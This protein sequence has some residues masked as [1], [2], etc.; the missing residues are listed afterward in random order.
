MSHGKQRV[1]GPLSPTPALLWWSGELAAKGRPHTRQGPFSEA[2][3]LN[4]C[5]LEFLLQIHGTLDVPAEAL[6]QE[7]WDLLLLLLTA[8][9]VT[10][11]RP[12]ASLCWGLQV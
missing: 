4:P 7:L 12:L 10:Q 11:G 3:R 6:S 9:Y 1:G 8:C 2:Q 5:S